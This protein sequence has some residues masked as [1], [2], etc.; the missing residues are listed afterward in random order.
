VHVIHLPRSPPHAHSAKHRQGRAGP[1]CIPTS[2]SHKHKPD[3]R[4]TLAVLGSWA[5]P[6]HLVESPVR[7]VV[8][9]P[10]A[11]QGAQNAR[12]HLKPA[13]DPSSRH[14]RP[15]SAPLA[16]GAS[17]RGFRHMP[18]GQ[19]PG[20]RPGFFRQGVPAHS[21]TLFNRGPGLPLGCSP[22]AEVKT[23]LGLRS[24]YLPRSLA[25]AWPMKPFL[26]AESR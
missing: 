14:L 23:A 19:Q 8:D 2:R 20:K 11:L 13:A 7:A 17:F 4:P 26:A 24:R 1:V 21:N 6:E 9:D 15:I 10:P 3:Q 22:V 12:L 25:L 16:N 18:G 5:E